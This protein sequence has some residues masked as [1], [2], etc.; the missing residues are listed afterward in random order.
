MIID[1]CRTS[2][3]INGGSFAHYTFIE[4]NNLQYF[5]IASSY[6]IKFVSFSGFS[7]LLI[8][9]YIVLYSNCKYRIINVTKSNVLVSS[10]R[11]TY[12]F[13]IQ[14]AQRTELAYLFLS[15][16]N[17]RCLRTGSNGWV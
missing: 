16:K 4:N 9:I 17:I 8:T 1:L 15:G 2:L 6:V 7:L 13:T 14:T 11:K 10:T 3:G 12:K 5:L